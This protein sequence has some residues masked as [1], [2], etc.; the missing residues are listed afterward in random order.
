MVKL[1]VDFRFIYLKALIKHAFF[2]IYLHQKHLIVIILLVLLV[3]HLVNLTLFPVYTHN[4]GSER[5]IFVR[6]ENVLFKLFWR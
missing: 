1:E 2:V 5:E 4:S 3:E 6:S